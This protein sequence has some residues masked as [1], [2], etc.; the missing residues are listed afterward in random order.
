[1]DPKGNWVQDA[2]TLAI[3]G[4]AVT[5]SYGKL[6][7]VQ[8]FSRSKA[9]L[10]I[11]TKTT[12]NSVQ[13]AFAE[14]VHAISFYNTLNGCSDDFAVN[15]GCAS[16]KV[17]R[18]AS[19]IVE[20][21]GEEEAVLDITANDRADEITIEITKS[22]QYGV[23]VIN[24]DNTVS[25]EANDGY[26]NSKIADH[27]A[28]RI[29]N[30]FGCDDAEVEVLVKCPTMEVVSGFSPNNDGIND[31][32]MIKGLENYPANELVIFN[33]WGTEIFKQK[34]YDGMWDGSFDGLPLTDGTYFYIL[35][36]GEGN[37]QSGYVQINR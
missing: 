18:A 28:Y 9:I 3:R 20:I 8:T 6:E 16:N 12:P 14:G 21:D 10:D 30:G 25:Y 4:G 35:K 13:M 31:Y 29:C 2:T 15:V 11:N 32:L 37:T 1:M 27:F 24:A 7:I 22:P 34:G 17:P 5:N 36:D 19:D 26:C 23:A 33:R